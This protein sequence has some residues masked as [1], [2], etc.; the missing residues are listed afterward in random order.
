MT[1]PSP[2]ILVRGGGDLASGAVA[3][4]HRAGFSVVVLELARPLAMRRLV[5]FAEAVYAGEIWVEE[6]HGVCVGGAEEAARALE[7]GAVPVWVDPEA[8]CRQHLRPVAIVDGR[9]RKRPPEPGVASSLPVIGLGPGFTA[10]LDC[11]AVVE[12]KRGAHLGR[13]IWQGN[14]ALDTRVP[15]PTSGFAE[16]RVL[17][18]PAAGEVL[19]LKALGSNVQEGDNVAEVAGVAVRAKF[20]GVLRGLMHDGLHVEA[21]AKLGDIDPRGDPSLCTLISDKALAVGGGVLEAV[22]SQAEIRRQLGAAR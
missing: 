22:L 3:R 4:L 2:L 14:A 6:M 9:M 5:S 7:A 16:E 1:P 12:T 15:E 17:R 18:S 8:E 19:G 20:A 21:G 13:V 10:G 11:L